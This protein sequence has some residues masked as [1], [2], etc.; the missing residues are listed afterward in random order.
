MGNLLIY[1]LPLAAVYAWYAWRRQKR[2]ARHK[3]ARDA[4]LAAGIKEPDS[5]HPLIDA[6]ACI[7]CAACVSACPE[8]PEHEVLGVIDG[9]AQLVSPSDCIG[10]GACRS[11]CPTHAIQLVFGSA[12]RGM[13]LPLL[14]ARFETNVPGIY[15]AGELG[16]M[17]LIRNA[18]TQGVQATQ[19]IAESLRGTGQSGQAGEQHFDLIIVGAGPAGFAAALTAKASGLRYLLLD[20]ESLGGCVFRYPRCKLVMTQSVDLPLIGRV[21][22]KSGTKEQLLEFWSQTCRTQQLNLRTQSRVESVQGVDGGF[23]LLAAG[24]SY[25]ARRVLLAIG[26]RGTP[27]KLDVAGEDLPKVVYRLV[28]P[29]QYRD[30]QVLVVGGGDSALEAAASIAEIAQGEVSLS[31]RGQGFSRAKP[32]NRERVA[33]LADSG[34]LRLLLESEVQ[35]I[36]PGSVQLQQGGRQLELPNDQVI[37]SAGGLLPT[38][39]LRKIGI[40][41]E[42]KYGTA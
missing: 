38:E 6:S 7:G 16:G 10:H 37:V 15:I 4:S 22:F 27:R 18:L 2:E 30:A 40:G 36:L 14:S 5:L 23:Q 39:F 25:H 29:E 19:F 32:R 8:A 13:D 21:Q 28:D 17:G 20:Q 34:K 24:A 42:T 26:R 31:Y 12:A 41:V 9:K 1:A 11:A 3:T 35:A 33:H